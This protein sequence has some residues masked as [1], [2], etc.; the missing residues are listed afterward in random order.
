MLTRILAAHSVVCERVLRGSKTTRFFF[1]STCST[2]LVLLKKQTKQNK[3]K[4]DVGRE[5]G[6]ARAGT[7]FI[8]NNFCKSVTAKSRI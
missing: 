5:G 8:R 7:K 3:N 4:S 6:G 1:T 2:H